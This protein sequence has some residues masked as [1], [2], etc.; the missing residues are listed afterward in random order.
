MT[1]RGTNYTPAAAKAM[2]DAVWMETVK[3][4]AETSPRRNANALAR[5]AIDAA[6]RRQE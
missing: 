6:G 4:Y 2:R 3:N 5:A 1:M